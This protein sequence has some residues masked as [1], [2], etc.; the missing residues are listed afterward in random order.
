VEHHVLEIE[1][2]WRVEEHNSYREKV[3]AHRGAW[4]SKYRIERNRIFDHSE[5]QLLVQGRLLRLRTYSDDYR[6]LLTY[7]GPTQEG[8]DLRVRREQ[9][10]GINHPDQLLKILCLVGFRE[11]TE[12]IT[13]REEWGLLGVKVV[14]DSIFDEKYIEIEGYERE[15]KELAAELGLA[16]EDQERESY[17]QKALR[18]MEET[19]TLL[20][21]EL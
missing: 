19:M 1:G 2:K 14:F 9:E 21:E 8:S 7:K 4:K 13:E 16:L 6:G 18:R 15:V 5:I 10:V 17:T 12:Y 11:M 20:E 3:K